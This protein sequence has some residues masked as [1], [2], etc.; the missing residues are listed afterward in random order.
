MFQR[1]IVYALLLLS[2]V[3]A[4]AAEPGNPAIR[5]AVETFIDARDISGAVTVV[6]AKDKLLAVDT[7]GLADIA[8]KKPMELDSLFWIASMTK[9]LTAV[10]ILM[11][12]DEGKLQVSD[13]V[14]KFIPEFAALRTPTGQPAHIT[15]E[16]ILTHTSGLGEGD[17][18]AIKNAHTLRELIPIY[19]A[20]P[21]LYEPGDHWRYTQSGINVAARIVEVTSGRSFDEFVS[22]R[23][24]K[25]L[26][27]KN[28][29][30]YPNKKQQSRLVTPYIKD[31][32][33]GSLTAAPYADYGNK[34]QPP[35]GNAGL[36]STGPDYARFCQML[37]NGG[38]F[39]GKR[40]LSPAAFQQLTTVHTGKLKTGF[41]QTEEYGSR[42]MNYGWGIGVAILKAPHP[43]VAE[44]LSPG[45][46][47]HGGAWGTQAWIDPVRGLAYILMVQRPGING[48][49]SKLRQAFQQAA[50]DAFP[51]P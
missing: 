31:K 48:D 11:L 3:F 26:G 13:P 14:E 23:I 15:I 17:R 38:T 51:Q 20:S 1:S 36:F 21:M 8:K 40:Y 50:S 46:F 9:P 29:T 19:L 18:A 32:Q 37:L 39:R 22:K 42:G 30:F 28:T 25:P 6:A 27:M 2:P 33:T 5:A 41:L 49:A 43:G 16:Q 35:L 45:T 12:Q 4:V 47:G 44:M 7:I 10:S 24:L 34:G